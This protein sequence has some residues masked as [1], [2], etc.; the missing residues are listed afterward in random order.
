MTLE[1]PTIEIKLRYY[2]IEDNNNR[3]EE[4]IVKR[5]QEEKLRKDLDN[6]LQRVSDKIDLLIKEYKKARTVEERS[7]I[8]FEIEKFQYQ[9]NVFIKSKQKYVEER[10]TTKFLTRSENG[11]NSDYSE[12]EKKH[13]WNLINSI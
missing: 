3:S 2:P 7:I 13:I 4:E 10:N 6:N 8:N 5:K 9:Y 11:D 1:N 12:E